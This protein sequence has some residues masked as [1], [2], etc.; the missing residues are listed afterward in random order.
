[1]SSSSSALAPVEWR[2][3]RN[4]PVRATSW[5]ELTIVV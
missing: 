3:S 4:P 2:S 5:I 1:M